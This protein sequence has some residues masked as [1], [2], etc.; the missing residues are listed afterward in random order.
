MNSFRIRDGRRMDTAAIGAM[1]RA[2]MAHHRALDT[3]FTLAPDAEQKYVRHVQ[4]M[5]R[6][7][8]A[9]ALVAEALD[10]GELIGYLLGEIQSRP[11]LAQPGLYGFISDIYVQE[12]WRQRGVGRALFEEMR[13]WFV[14]RKATAIELYIAE[15]NPMA[16][17]FWQE[18]G[19]SPFLKLLHLDL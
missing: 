10:T 9:R 1:W 5:I 17:A 7:R 18:M 14:D 6:S 8:N 13:R 12:A 3:R 4:E 16:V 2:L 19:L 11:P 15:A